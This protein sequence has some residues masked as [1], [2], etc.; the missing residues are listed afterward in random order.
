MMCDSSISIIDCQLNSKCTFYD[1]NDDNKI[2]D[3]IDQSWNVLHPLKGNII[4]E[5]LSFF[6]F[7]KYLNTQLLRTIFVCIL[8]CILDYHG[9]TLITLM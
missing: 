1:F 9:I 8:S 4:Y 2:V 3:N 6:F 7:S 5:R